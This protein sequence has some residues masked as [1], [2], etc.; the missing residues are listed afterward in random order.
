MNSS[1]ILIVSGEPNSV[2][3]ELFF[4]VFNNN[5]IK[6]PIIL[7][8]SKRLINLQM[9]KLGFKNK[10]RL[11]DA[12][13]LES[14]KLDNKTINLIDV[15]YNP[16]KAFEKISSKSNIFIKNSFELAFK[17]IKKYN[18]VKF[19]NGPISK[20]YF[21][22]KEFLGITEYIS[23]KFLTKKTCMLIFNKKLSVCPITTHLP[24][25]LVSKKIT[26]K[27]IIDKVALID[28]FYKKNLKFKPRIAILGLNPHCESIHTFN[29]DEKIIQ[30]SI[31]YLKKKYN[32][33]GPYPADTIF[34]KNNRKNFDVIVGMY[35]DQVLTPIKTLYEYDA[36][37]ITLGLP[38]I[39]ISPDHGPNETMLGRNLSNPLSLLRAIKFL[40]RN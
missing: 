39:R 15:K 4:K 23:E 22:K 24:L 3:I 11:I 20:K 1:P 37:N 19:I 32:V 2:F 38:F 5:K 40:D 29:E 36:I 28:N 13:N 18:I 8:S 31:K 17:I 7:I 21:L 14:Y 30:P 35:H 12:S 27:N 25:K 34:L 6:S 16:D 9:K 33:S 26:K 10:I